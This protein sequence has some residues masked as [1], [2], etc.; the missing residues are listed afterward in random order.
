MNTCRISAIGMALLSLA[1]CTAHGDRGYQGWVEADLIFVSP[2]EAGRVDMLAVR[3]GQKVQTG[4][5]LF[6]VDPDLQLADVEMARA[7]LTN[8]RQAFDRAQT[9]YKTNAGT[10]KTVEDAEATLR[11]A[12]A[13]LNSA[14]TRLQR[15]KMSSPVNGSVQQIYY[16]PGESVPAARPIVSLLPPGNIKVRFFVPETSLGGITPG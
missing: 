2:D 13:R 14:Q 4:D 3:E 16:R 5:P 15:R 9:L 10:Q 8:A 11:T 6:S 1:A 7:A 12:E